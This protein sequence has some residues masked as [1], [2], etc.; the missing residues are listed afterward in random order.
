MRVN[1]METDNRDGR[2]KQEREKDQG[3]ES[4]EK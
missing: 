2:K 4:K 3:A 1:R